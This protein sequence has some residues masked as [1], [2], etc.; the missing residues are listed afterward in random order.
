MQLERIK[1][2]TIPPAWREVWITP[3]AN[4]HLQAVG[5]DAAGRRQYLYHDDWRRRRDQ[6]KFDHMLEF[7]HV[8]P[9]LRGGVAR[10][11]RQRNLSRRRVLACAVRLL[12]AGFFRIG[13]DAYAD[14]NGSYGLATLERR[15]VV[16]E[17]GGLLFDYRAKGGQ[18]RLQHI[19]DPAARRVIA[20]LRKR[21]GGGSRLLA[22]QERPGGRWHD[23]VSGDIN[24]YIKERTGA[25]VT[26]KDFRTWHAT[27]LAAAGLAASH[28]T[29][30]K[31][32]REREI[33]R[34]IESVAELLGN[35]P[36]VCRASYI[37]PRVFDLYRSG[38]TIAVEDSADVAGL[39]TAVL[40]LFES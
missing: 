38:S 35:T 9:T 15:H 28:D 24:A 32:A 14:E 19:A 31:T 3:H 26:A 23:V 21:R 20:A 25:E 16:T 29:G 2:L 11:L 27:V 33:R 37:D 10:D 36:A 4:G 1:A 40:A 39:E 22:Y 30:S 8:L 7:A 13:S 34:V 17:R 6:E 18:R 5:T 12:D